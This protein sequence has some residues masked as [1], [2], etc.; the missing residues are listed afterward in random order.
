MGHDLALR[1][2]GV[3]P[4]RRPTGRGAA[5][6]L[7]PLGR[8]CSIQTRTPWEITVSPSDQEHVETRIRVALAEL[9]LERERARF[10]TVAALGV[11]VGVAAVIATVVEAL[12]LQLCP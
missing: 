7:S 8:P 2:A 10:L 1:I 6:S 11:G 9:R 5:S 4:R 3:A 12:G